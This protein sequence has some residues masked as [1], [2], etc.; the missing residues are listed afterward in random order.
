M[1]PLPMERHTDQTPLA[2][3]GLS[4]APRE[5]ATAQHFLHHADHWRD[6]ACAQAADRFSDGRLERV[7]Q[8]HRETGLVGW[9]RRQARNAFLPP[10]MLR[11]AARG[12]GRVN[13]VPLTRLA[14]T[15]EGFSPTDG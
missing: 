7:G 15:E 6:R 5:L 12:H 11:I 14:R 4:A 1:Q 3:G 9:G 13:P 2:T 8:L 10:R